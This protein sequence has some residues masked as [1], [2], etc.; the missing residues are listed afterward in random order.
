MILFELQEHV[1]RN[2]RLHMLALVF[3][4]SRRRLF[5][6]W[7]N[8][9]RRLVSDF[10]YHTS[11]ITHSPEY[12][13]LWRQLRE[14]SEFRRISSSIYQSGRP[15]PSFVFRMQHSQLDR[16]ALRT[17]TT[18]FTGVTNYSMVSYLPGDQQTLAIYR[19]HGWQS[20]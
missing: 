4:P 10:Q 20:S 3:D 2:E 12:K 16:I 19:T 14:S 15:S 5:P 11:R 1:A 18:V 8:L 9:A 6:G 13:A 7:E 17:A